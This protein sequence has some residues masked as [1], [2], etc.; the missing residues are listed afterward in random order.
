MPSEPLSD[1]AI[2]EALQELAGWSRAEKAL[3]KTF[4]FADFRTAIAFMVRAG[5]E[6]EGAN[7]HPEWTNVYN[8]VEVRLCTHDA[9]N[10]I[11]AKDVALARA[12]NRL[13]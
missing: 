7:H 4:E 11:T 2:D 10:Q 5:F 9:G 3:S 12:M 6:A 13:I 1:T 8:R